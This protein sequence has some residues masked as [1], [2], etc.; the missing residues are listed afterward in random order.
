MDDLE[1]GWLLSCGSSFLLSVLHQL[2]LQARLSLALAL[3]YSI[4]SHVSC[5]SFFSCLFFTPSLL[6]SFQTRYLHSAVLL[7]DH[8]L[9]FGGEHITKKLRK[10]HSH[11]PDRKLNDL[12]TY[13]IPSNTW[14]EASPNECKANHS[15]VTFVGLSPSGV[16]LLELGLLLLGVGL[17]GG[18]IC[19]ANH[20]ARQRGG[21]ARWFDYCRPRM[22]HIRNTGPLQSPYMT[23]ELPKLKVPSTTIGIGRR[24]GYTSIE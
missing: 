8:L 13:S 14:T 15:P 21:G 20:A 17:S 7:H 11:M 1:V 24:A 4:S 22:A 12:W 3:T 9:V 19:V 16:L 6:P 2:M 18:L 23:V 5:S 10:E